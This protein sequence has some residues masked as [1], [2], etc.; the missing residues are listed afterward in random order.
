VY[1]AFAYQALTTGSRNVA[2]GWGAMEYSAGGAE[3]I[4]IGPQA[5]QNNFA[6]VNI[7]IG[8]AAMLGNTTGSGNTAVGVAALATNLTGIEN[9]AFGTSA[10]RGSRGS[11]NIAIG[12]LAGSDLDAGSDN[13][14]VG[15]LGLAADAATIR[16]GTDATHVATYIAGIRGTTTNS[17]DA[18]PVVIDSN[19]QLGTI[20]SSRRYKED[21]H[22]MLSASD[23]LFKLRPVTFRYK[24]PYSNGE[25]PLQFGLIAEEVAEVF[26]ELAIYNKEG[27]PET[28]AYHLL[29][30]L[31]LN[32]L[33]KEHAQV[34]Q[35]R[36][37]LKAARALVLEQSRQ[38]AA[39][40]SRLSE[41]DALRAD[42]AELKAL[43]A[44]HADLR[45]HAGRAP[46]RI[47]A[48]AISK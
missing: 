24:K 42:I 38:L 43:T 36:R 1:G 35:Q 22:S 31:L 12:N 39:M 27:K 21:I 20:S 15:N 18:V 9:S 37:D 10:L 30:T 4:A 25:K 33:Q 34:E 8:D 32:E 11:H 29:P 40:N 5:L 7:A 6:D 48:I 14:D 28:V 23:R 45:T 46:E 19:G 41:V 47:A 16:I 3:N 26:P 17:A 13:I 44:L 2:V